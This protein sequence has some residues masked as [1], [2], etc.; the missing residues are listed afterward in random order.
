VH[1]PAEI[2]DRSNRQPTVSS[3]VKQAASIVTWLIGVGYYVL[4]PLAISAAI[5]SLAVRLARR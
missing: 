5:A 2:P 1:S 3:T 4:I